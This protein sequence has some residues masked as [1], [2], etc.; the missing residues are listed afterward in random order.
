PFFTGK[1]ATVPMP[2]FGD[3][4]LG[5]PFLFDIGVYLVVAGTCLTAVFALKEEPA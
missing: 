1:W 3:V 5:T 4:K 2:G